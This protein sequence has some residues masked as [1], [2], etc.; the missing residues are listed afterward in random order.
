MTDKIDPEA[1][2]AV[3]KD[4]LYREE[5]VIELAGLLLEDRLGKLPEGSVLAV[6]IISSYA[7]HPQRLESHRE[8]VREWLAL[9]PPE[10]RKSEGGGWSFLNACNQANGEQW[11]GLHLRMEQLFCLAIGLGLAKWLGPRDMW[12]VF[13]GGMPYVVIDI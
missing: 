9:L 10:F 8:Q 7:F 1:V 2:G 3:L 6:G 11:T 5:E 12:D 13:P 4:C